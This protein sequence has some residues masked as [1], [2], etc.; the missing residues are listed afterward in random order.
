M[1]IL[2]PVLSVGTL[3][4][5][6]GAGLGIAAKKFCVSTDPRLE[7][8]LACLPGANCGACGKAGCLGF[9]ESLIQ[10]QASINQC[11]V[12]SEEARN[13]IS[14]ILKIS[15]EKKVKRIAVLHC[16][17]GKRVKDKFQY[18]GLK[19]CLAANLVMGGQKECKYGCL[20]FGTCVRACP[21]GAIKMGEDDL[22]VVDETRCR[23]CGRCVA[24]CPKKLFSLTDIDKHYFVACKSFEIGKKVL[25]VCKV[26]CIACGRCQKACPVGA[27]NVI[28]NLAQFDYKKCQNLGECAKVCPTKAIVKR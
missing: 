15:V 4:L 10:G 19:D 20:G 23:A 6:F 5:L 28:D 22:P 17:G 3:G 24:I 7:K 2:I 12:S 14:K 9:A 26:G 11:A 16:H 25:D 18:E 8:I 13:E 1:N 21:F 27:I